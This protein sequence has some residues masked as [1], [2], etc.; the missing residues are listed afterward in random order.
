MAITSVFQTEEMGS[1]PIIRWRS[2]SAVHPLYGKLTEPTGP[3]V[4]W[5]SAAPVGS[6]G[7]YMEP[8]SWAA[9]QFLLSQGVDARVVK[10]GGL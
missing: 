2:P 4:M 10:G 6:V 5:E 3:S 8:T 1:I 7:C 9:V